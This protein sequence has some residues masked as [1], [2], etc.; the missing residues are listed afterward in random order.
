MSKKLMFSFVLFFVMFSVSAQF[1]K[2]PA[3]VTDSF[4]AKY[5]NASGV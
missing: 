2:I 3:V 5:K 4:K 1:R